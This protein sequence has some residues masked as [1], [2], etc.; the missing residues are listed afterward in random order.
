MP[1]RRFSPLKSPILQRLLFETCVALERCR[2]LNQSI[3]RTNVDDELV[4]SIR[5]RPDPGAF[6]V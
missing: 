6:G 1:H 3:D 5:R 2:T 4:E